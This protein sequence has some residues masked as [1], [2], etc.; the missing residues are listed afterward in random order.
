MARP[1][2]AQRRARAGISLLRVLTPALALSC[3]ATAPSRADTH[4]EPLWEYALGFGTVAFQDYPG[5]DTTRVYPVPAARLI[6]NGAFLK[7]DQNGVRGLLFDQRW[8]ELNV[9]GGVSAPVRNDAAR[10]GLPPLKA[11]LEIGPSVDFHLIRSDADRLRLDLRL[12]T[13]A[14]YTVAAPPEE[15]G[16]KFEPLLR[17][18]VRDAFGAQGWK[19]EFSSGPMLANKKYDTYFYGIASRYAT[20]YRPAYAPN[21][22]YAGAQFGAGIGKRFP[23]L[24]F[25]ASVHY[26]ALGGANFA[27]SPLVQRDYDWSVGLSFAW[28]IGKSARVVDVAW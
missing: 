25:D 7:A 14:V 18:R 5:S 20:A 17:L 11:T 1:A 10:S 15:I 8:V 3:V 12:P 26:E 2:L 21:G 9:S 27:A 16:W 19:L 24:W 6:Y 4:Q 22:G 23:K 13:R 28:V